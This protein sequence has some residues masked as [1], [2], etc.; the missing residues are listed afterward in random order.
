MDDDDDELRGAAHGRRTRHLE[1]MELH[2]E[3][4]VNFV[5][6]PVS[7]AGPSAAG[8]RQP[9]TPTNQ[10]PLVLLAEFCVRKEYTERYHDLNTIAST[11]QRCLN[12]RHQIVVEFNR[13]ER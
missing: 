13:K 11:P 10:Q 4:R 3:R 6:V 8:P 1:N 5:K 12:K 9:D 7:S 2:K